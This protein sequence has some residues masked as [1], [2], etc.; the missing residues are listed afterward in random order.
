MQ[1]MRAGLQAVVASSATMV[2]W[3]LAVGAG[4]VAAIVGT[5][6]L[7]PKQRWARLIY[8]LFP[9]GWTLMGWSIYYGNAIARDGVAAQ[10]VAQDQALQGIGADMNSTYISQQCA[11]TVGLAVFGVWLLL[12]LAWWIFNDDFPKEKS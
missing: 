12:Y 5:S 7:R 8:L 10:L 11:L 1:D 2:T 9:V 3:A 6:Y 4:S